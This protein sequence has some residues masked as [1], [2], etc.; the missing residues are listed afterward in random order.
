MF[1][2]RRFHPR[3]WSND[4]LREIGSALRGCSS[5]I[6][7]SGW[8]DGDKEGGRYRDYFPSMGTYSVSNHPGDSAKGVQ[9]GTDLSLDLDSDLAP[10]LVGSYDVVLNHTVL[11]HVPRPWFAIDVMAQMARK[12]VITVVPFKQPLHYSPGN[13]GDFYRFTPM[14][15][16]SSFER[17]GMHVV[18]ESASAGVDTI[19]L[20]HVAVR[21]ELTLDTRAHATLDLDA[22]N[23][24]LGAVR[25]IDVLRVLYFRVY[26]RL[27]SA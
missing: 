7:V 1:D 12:A 16:R 14:A 6:N 24:R 11:E 19:Y 13:F 15:M 5:M 10:H 23:N 25:P 20:L 3:Y 4:R 22:L 27:F 2:Y 21:D 9:Q 26:G 8:R 17:A 18:H